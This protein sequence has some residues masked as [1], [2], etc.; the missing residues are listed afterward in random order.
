MRISDDEKLPKWS[1]NSCTHCSNKYCQVF[2]RPVSLSANKCFYHSKYKPQMGT[3][4]L[5][6]NLDTI[7]A[8][9]AKA[10]EKHYKGWLHEAEL[11][12]LETLKE[13]E[14]EQKSA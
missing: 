13:I 14:K 12:R 6:K 4:K 2:Q 3:F 9:E 1:C 11:M 5:N 10:R 8:A 7:M